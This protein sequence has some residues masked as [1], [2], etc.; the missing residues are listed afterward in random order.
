[1]CRASADHSTADE[2]H[3][4]FLGSYQREGEK[5]GAKKPLGAMNDIIEFHA[6]LIPVSAWTTRGRELSQKSLRYSGKTEILR[7]LEESLAE[8]RETF[9]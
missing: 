9:E 3:R 4:G 5:R 2:Y 7:H 1:V 8:F 6:A